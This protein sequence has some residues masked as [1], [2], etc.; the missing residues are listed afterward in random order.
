MKTINRPVSRDEL[1]MTETLHHIF[2]LLEA[3]IDLGFETNPKWEQLSEKQI[4]R[5]RELVVLLPPAALLTC[6]VPQWLKKL[7]ELVDR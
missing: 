7:A 4:C 5:L 1:S 2:G 6:E 3:W